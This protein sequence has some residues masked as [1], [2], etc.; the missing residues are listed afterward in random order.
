MSLI[1]TAHVVVEEDVNLLRNAFITVAP[2]LVDIV[3]QRILN[4]QWRSKLDWERGGAPLTLA[5]V[6]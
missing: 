4:A 3:I 5:I 2:K 6:D 1:V